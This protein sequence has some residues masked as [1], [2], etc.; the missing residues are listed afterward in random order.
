MTKETTA[1]TWS[2]EVDVLALLKDDRKR[3]RIKG[4]MLFLLGVFITA[5]LIGFGYL[6]LVQ[7]PNY[8]DEL[9]KDRLS[10]YKT[11]SLNSRLVE[12]INLTNGLIRIHKNNQ[13]LPINYMNDNGEEVKG[14]LYSDGYLNLLNEQYVA[15]QSQSTQATTT[16]N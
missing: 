4:N 15:N 7:Q 2:V 16:Q 8:L 1:Q 3:L 5:G 6:A 10:G 14:A 11:I 12:N 9:D 13:A